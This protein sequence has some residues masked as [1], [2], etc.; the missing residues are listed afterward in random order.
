M[1]SRASPNDSA[2]K[3]A[4]HA[5]RG[6][7]APTPDQEPPSVHFDSDFPSVCKECAP[8]ERTWFMLDQILSCEVQLNGVPSEDDA[9]RRTLST[10]DGAGE[11]RLMPY[12]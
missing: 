9:E 11:S 6:A 1:E 3:L 4:P 10:C 12:L 2:I 8:D 5:E 7:Q